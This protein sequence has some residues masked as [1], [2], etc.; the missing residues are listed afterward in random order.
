LSRVSWSRRFSQAISEGDGIS[1][2]ADVATPD[3]AVAAEAAGAEAIVVR[4]AVSGAREATALPILW[5]AT[6]PLGAALAAGADAVL[7]V[8]AELDDDE[9]RLEAL[10][11]EAAEAGLDCVVAVRDDDELEL[12]LE[13]V[14]P[15]VFLLR[16]PPDSDD[17]LEHVLSLLPDVPAGK[18]A[19]AELDV[20]DRD[21]V[22]EL[23]R[24]GFDGVVAPAAQV[25]ELLTAAPPAY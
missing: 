10:Y 13:R 24:A 3:E 19:V 12:A 1:L 23:E 16:A 22:D 4:T 6:G 20:R 11:A 21:D 8:L 2:L 5:C 14:D 25:A 15:E 7:L 17:G 18:L 9:E